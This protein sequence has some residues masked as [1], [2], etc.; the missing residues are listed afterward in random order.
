M[1]DNPLRQIFDLLAN[2]SNT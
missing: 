1:F 2:H